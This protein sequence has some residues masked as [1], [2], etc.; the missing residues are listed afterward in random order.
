MR[1]AAA[2]VR[3][4]YVLRFLHK[5]DVN[6]HVQLPMQ[7]FGVDIQIPDRQIQ[8]VFVPCSKLR[9]RKKIRSYYTIKRLGGNPALIVVHHKKKENLSRSI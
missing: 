8:Q 9:A 6:R 7:G 5:L 4:M 1:I 3:Q 2:P